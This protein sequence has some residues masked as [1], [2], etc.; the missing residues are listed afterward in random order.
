MASI[1]LQRTQ[2][3]EDTENQLA[4]I[5]RELLGVESIGV[6]QNFFDLGGDSSLAVRM[7][8]EIEK[9]FKVKLPLATLYETPTI[10]ELGRVLRGETLTSGWSPLVAI[11][12]AGSRPP[13]FCFHGAG[14]NVLIYRDL[15]RVERAIA[16]ARRGQISSHYQPGHPHAFHSYIYAG[17][18]HYAKILHDPRR[19]LETLQQRTRPYPSAL[20]RAA[21]GGRGCLD[22]RYRPDRPARRQAR[23][24][25]GGNRPARHHLRRRNP[26]D[27]APWPSS[28]CGC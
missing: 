2:M 24:T 17:E 12:L 16:D 15:S 8:A 7:F 9:A 4:G 6:D 1:N 13:L 27:P 18:V 11:Q 19:R 28:R 10:E 22:R 14:G 26:E 20:R 5:W 3:E 23:R 21:A 25:G